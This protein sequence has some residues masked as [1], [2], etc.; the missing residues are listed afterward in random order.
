[1][2]SS[3]DD[4]ANLSPASYLSAGLAEALRRPLDYVRAVGELAT[5]CARAYH[6][7]PRSLQKQLAD[8]V[9]LAIQ[10]CSWDYQGSAALARLMEM[11]RTH[12]PQKRRQE[13]LRMHKKEA[14]QAQRRSHKSF[15]DPDKAIDVPFEIIDLICWHLDPYSLGRTACVSKSWREAASAEPI[16]RQFLKH[17]RAAAYMRCHQADAR[18]N[19]LFGMLASEHSS[20]MDCWRSSRRMNIMSKSFPVVV[21]LEW[22]SGDVSTARYLAALDM[23][24]LPRALHAPSV[25]QVVAHVMGESIFDADAALQ[26]LLEHDL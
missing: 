20:M 10:Q 22:A 3:S 19:V 9:A 23:D 24:H 25:D 18:N 21:R 12:L 5:V 7:S 2:D 4:D 17:S 1:M 13:L 15:V 6:T 26:G 14:L 8:D 16:W 11:A